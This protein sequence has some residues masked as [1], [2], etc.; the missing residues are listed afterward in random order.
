[1]LRHRQR[2]GNEEGQSVVLHAGEFYDGNEHV[3]VAPCAEEETSLSSPASISL[4]FSNAKASSSS[5]NVF[6]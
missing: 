6:Q 2:R 4:E 1:M 5:A 3:K